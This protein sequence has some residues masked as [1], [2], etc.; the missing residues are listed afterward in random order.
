MTASLSCP[1][2]ETRLIDAGPEPLVL[3]Q[4]GS[5]APAAWVI[6]VHAP[7]ENRTGNNYWQARAADA[8]ARAGFAAVRFDLSGYGESLGRMNAGI[9]DEQLRGAVK[10]AVESGATAVHVTGRGLHSALLAGLAVPGLRIALYPPSAADLNWWSGP[11]RAGPRDGQI[12][13]AHRPE[14]AE[15]AFW[16]ACGAESSL[17]GGFACPV[18]VIDALVQR[19]AAAS[20]DDWDLVVAAA[21]DRRSRSARLI[22]GRDPLTR[23]ESDR[24]GLERL[25]TGWLRGVRALPAG[26]A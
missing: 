14:P 24:A 19:I 13:A 26:A 23:L 16:E 22:C 4:P 12:E 18:A 15:R 21:D 6:M 11:G 3:H 7:G 9:W 25:L 8:L 20:Q 1:A 2:P 5:S 17:I 10:V